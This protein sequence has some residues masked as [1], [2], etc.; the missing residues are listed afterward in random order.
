M[1]NHTTTTI[2]NRDDPIPVFKMPR[3][4]DGTP[5]PAEPAP[6]KSG[7]KREAFKREA[8]RLKGKFQDV[9][10]QYK[11]SQGT[12][13]ERMFNAYVSCAQP[14]LMVQELTCAGIQPA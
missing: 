14:D 4:D 12:V 2:S 10:A 11:T 3:L 1:D 13:Q 6:P 5:S 7:S 9:G 8:E